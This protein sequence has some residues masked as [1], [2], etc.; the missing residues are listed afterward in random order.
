VPSD[1]RQKE[2]DMNK[3]WILAA[4][5]VA[6]LAGCG[7]G[8]GEDHPATEAVPPTASQSASGFIDYMKRL[9][10]SAADMLEP[11]DGSQVTPPADDTAEPTPV[12]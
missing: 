7:G 4:C 12:D 3:L 6:T 8:G 10:V 11:V 1:A 9:V 2:H 5:V